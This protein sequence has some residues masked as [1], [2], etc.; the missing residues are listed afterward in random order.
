MRNTFSKRL[1]VVV[2]LLL[3]I[4]TFTGCTFFNN[5]TNSNGVNTN[6]QNEEDVVKKTVTVQV[7]D[8]NENLIE[9]TTPLI[10]GENL[11]ELLNKSMI[12]TDNLKFEFDTFEFNDEV[13]FFI[14][15]ING[16]NPSEDNKFWAFK[17]N[18]E[19]SPVG[20]SDYMPQADDVI[21][22]ELD[23]IN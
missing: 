2:I 13:S 6:T 23:T 22:F 4:F 16:Y 19:L 15:S 11:Y 10:D 17:V 9:T 1:P 8:Q 14:T 12:S 18:D 21:K 3:S 7:I 20:I 5:D